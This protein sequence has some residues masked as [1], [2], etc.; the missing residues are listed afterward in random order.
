MADGNISIKIS[1]DALGVVDSL[2]KIGVLAGDAGKAG[3]SAGSAMETAWRGVITEGVLATRQVERLRAQLDQ[4]KGATRVKGFESFGGMITAFNA[5]IQAVSTLTAGVQ[6]LGRA[7]WESAIKPAMELEDSLQRVAALSGGGDAGMARAREMDAVANAWQ[8]TSTQGN[9]E[10]SARVE[11]AMRAGLQMQD[12]MRAVQATFVAAQ[13]KQATADAMLQQ[14]IAAAAKGETTE[15]AITFFERQGL[16]I[17]T[18]IADYTGVARDAV[19]D[20]AKSGAIQVNDLLGALQAMT[21]RGTA[22]WDSFQAS[23]STT[24]AEVRRAENDWGDM[25]KAIGTELLPVVAQS[26][27]EISAAVRSLAPELRDAANILSRSM[28]AALKEAVSFVTDMVDA[29]K[30]FYTWAMRGQDA[31][32]ADMRDTIAA[33]DHER[34]AARDRAAE[35]ARSSESAEPGGRIQAS[36]TPEAARARHARAAQLRAEEESAK[37]LLELARRRADAEQQRILRSGTAQEVQAAARDLSAAIADLLRQDQALAAKNGGL[38]SNERM[39]VQRQLDKLRTQQQGLTKR[40]QDLQVAGLAKILQQRMQQ[41]GKKLQQ[42]GIVS[43]R[44]TVTRSSLAA[45]GGGG[46]SFTSLQ[47]VQ[48]QQVKQQ[49]AS[50]KQLEDIARK[51]LNIMPREYVATLA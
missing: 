15:R 25:L 42:G 40:G 48:L 35:F 33:R 38:M 3:Q 32:D 43:E 9:N 31:A 44:S 17:K 2:K 28:L 29:A 45:I 39:D 13:G 21:S 51:M 47:S 36:E 4:L 23:L 27:R 6:A 30:Y 24:S 12:A 50:L 8:D 41:E 49:T 16:D 37:N 26:M 1:A 46:G 11:Q 5:G 20:M 22:A 10:F 14:I 18:A 7:L 19:E 34:R